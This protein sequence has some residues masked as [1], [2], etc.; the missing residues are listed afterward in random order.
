MAN[1][2]CP[3]SATRPRVG[4]SRPPSRCSSVLLPDPEAPTMATDSP[5]FTSKST[6]SSTC[7]S[8]MPCRKVLP[9]PLQRSTNTLIAQRLRRIDARSAPAWEQ[10]RGQTDEERDTG[11]EANVTPYKL[12]R[13][14]ADVVHVGREQVDADH[15]LDDWQDGFDVEREQ[16]A[17]HQP[18]QRAE[19]PDDRTLD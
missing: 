18:Q 7:T 13:Q 16:Y 8:T 2:S 9:N 17:A 6:S 12:G 19:H 5:A 3:S 4:T 14:F 1:G 11:N 10:R 15:V